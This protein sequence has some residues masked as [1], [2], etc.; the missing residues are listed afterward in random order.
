MNYKTL[1]ASG[2]AVIVS[3][4][5]IGNAY[6]MEIANDAMAIT[7]D[8][9]SGVVSLI[10]NN[11]DEQI[12]PT[13]LFF[14]T[15]PNETTLHTKD[16]KLEKYKKDGDSINLTFVRNDFE[17]DVTLNVIKQRYVSVDYKI[18]A[19]GNDRKIK[20]ITFLPTKKQTQAPYVD[21]SINSSPIIADT[22]FMLPRKP[23]VN[24]YAYETK[25]NLNIDIVTPISTN[26]PLKYTT[27]IPK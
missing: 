25:T 16:F 15:L 23:I 3:A 4:A 14:I 21:G 18:K 7:F 2:L 20:K 26:A 24:T 8:N 27:Y 10:N 13:E 9:N 12:T 5:Y 17:V 19:V 6:S 11:T 22:F 1:K